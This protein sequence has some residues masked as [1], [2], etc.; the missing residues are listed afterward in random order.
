MKG[1]CGWS[2]EVSAE[3]GSQVPP[4]MVEE[5]PPGRTLPGPVCEFLPIHGWVPLNKVC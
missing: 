1:N 3:A 4:V 2:Q 5:G